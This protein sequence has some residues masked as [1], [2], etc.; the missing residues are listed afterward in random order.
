MRKKEKGVV[1]RIW[2]AENTIGLEFISLYLLMLVPVPTMTWG[3]LWSL[4]VNCYG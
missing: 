4:V 1:P 3:H 2:E